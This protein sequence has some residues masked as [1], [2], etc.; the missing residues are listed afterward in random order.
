MI[1]EELKDWKALLKLNFYTG[2]SVRE[3]GPYRFFQS[4]VYEVQGWSKDEN[5]VEVIQR[6]SYSFIGNVTWPLKERIS[7]LNVPLVV[8]HKAIRDADLFVRRSIERAA[9]PI[10]DALPL[11]VSVTVNDLLFGYTDET[12]SKIPKIDAIFRRHNQ[13]L[14]LPDSI[15][16]DHVYSVL[17]SVG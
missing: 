11:F 5:Y 7:S 8:M 6:K 4:S 1:S 16:S 9:K 17:G 10:L 2:D 15:R 14:V 3:V 12:L 13:R